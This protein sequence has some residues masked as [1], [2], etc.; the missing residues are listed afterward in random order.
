MNTNELNRR[1]MRQ[2][3]NGYLQFCDP[4]TSEWINLSKREIKEIKLELN[5][6]EDQI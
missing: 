5:Q 3:E 2:T 6:F 4:E 1:G